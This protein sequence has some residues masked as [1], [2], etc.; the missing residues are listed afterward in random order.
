MVVI[1]RSLQ[2]L[3]FYTG[4]NE[5]DG[6]DIVAFTYSDVAEYSVEEKV[7]LFQFLSRVKLG[8]EVL[9]Q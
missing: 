1:T 8:Y 3:L 5:G 9:T 7:S 2:L 6:V 4:V